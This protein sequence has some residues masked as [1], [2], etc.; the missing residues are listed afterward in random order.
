M[1]RQA[2][3]ARLKGRRAHGRMLHR[4]KAGTKTRAV[5]DELLLGLE[6]DAARL[7]AGCCATLRTEYG[8]QIITQNSQGR[9]LGAYVGSE[10]VPLERLS[11]LLDFADDC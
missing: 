10:Y 2:S 7:K 5:F 9:L 8:F 11:T 4:P 3:A 1:F 6:V